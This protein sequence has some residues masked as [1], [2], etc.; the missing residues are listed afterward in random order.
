[1]ESIRIHPKGSGRVT[2]QQMVN[3]LSSTNPEGFRAAQKLLTA[4]EKFVAGKGFFSTPESRL[5]KVV[6]QLLDIEFSISQRPHK[7]ETFT[8]LLGSIGGGSD[9]PEARCAVLFDY[10]SK[11]SDAFPNWQREYEALNEL[12]PMYVKLAARPVRRA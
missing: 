9:D 10:L 4:T 8:A 5:T 3:Y 1:M 11:V 2:D 7:P 12:V 6:D